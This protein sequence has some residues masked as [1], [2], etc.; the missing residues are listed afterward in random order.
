MGLDRDFKPTIG[1]GNI[2]RVIKTIGI[3]IGMY[4]LAVI[5]E[6]IVVSAVPDSEGGVTLLV[7]LTLLG[8]MSTKVGYRWFDCFFALI[9]FYGVFFLFRIT[10]RVAN[11]P[12]RDWTD[13]GISA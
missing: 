13:R 12:A 3:V 9:P 4:L 1:K 2:V 11:L 8:F 6:L 5:A 7:L 10:Y